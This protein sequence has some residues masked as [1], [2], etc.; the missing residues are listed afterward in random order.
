M[1]GKEGER[2]RIGMYINK[3]G[4]K[5]GVS[6]GEANF[7]QGHVKVLMCVWGRVGGA[8]CILHIVQLHWEVF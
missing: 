5:L 1:G 3:L 8:T 2:V 4:V 6:G 7:N